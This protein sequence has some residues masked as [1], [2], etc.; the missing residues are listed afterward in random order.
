VVVLA[1]MM[2]ATTMN[3]S[4]SAAGW[5]NSASSVNALDSGT[6]PEEPTNAKAVMTTAQDEA[7][8]TTAKP[9]TFRANKARVNAL[10]HAAVADVEPA[11]SAKDDNAEVP[12]SADS[13]AWFTKD[14]DH[15]REETAS[16]ITAESRSFSRIVH[17]EDNEIILAAILESS[18]AASLEELKADSDNFYSMVPSAITIEGD[19]D[20]INSDDDFPGVEES[21]LIFD[22]QCKNCAEG[23]ASMSYLLVIN[24]IGDIVA[25]ETHNETM[26]V[27]ALHPSPTN[28][29]EVYLGMNYDAS[30]NGPAAVWN[31][32]ESVF[33]QYGE[34]GYT[35]NSHDV[36]WAEE[37]SL[38]HMPAYEE[39]SFRL[40]DLDDGHEKTRLNISGGVLPGAWENKD[41]SLVDVNHFQ[42]D[43]M[44]TRVYMSF[45]DL[46]A[47]IKTEEFNLDMNNIHGTSVGVE[48]I[49]GSHNGTFAIIDLDGT[50][51]EPG[52]TEYN[53]LYGGVGSL[54][55]GQHNLEH[56]GNGEF[57]MFDNAY[58]MNSEEWTNPD[59]SRMLIVQVDEEEET[60]TLIWE[61]QM[62]YRSEIFG[63]NDRLPSGNLLGCAWPDGSSI[64]DEV[65]FDAEIVEVVRETGELAWNMKVW[66][67]GERSSESQEIYGWMMYSVERVY[68][69]PLILSQ[70]CSTGNSADTLAFDTFNNFKQQSE[71]QG[72]YKVTTTSGSEVA[73]GAVTWSAHW[74]RTSIK[75]KMWSGACSGGCTLSLTNLAGDVGEKT[76]TC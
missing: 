34:Y 15:D 46:S 6:A 41:W 26:S 58:D 53:Q 56:F 66:G 19:L 72:T 23:D 30:E 22:L 68:E 71:V 49:A 13:Q 51:Y 42:F 69:E 75:V 14:F 25:V 64:S 11:S 16:A 17:L 39:F 48:W 24:L 4:R 50:R 28:S 57:F 35:G 60:V 73:S 32:G 21:Y 59:G 55:A 27:D 45:R 54:W 37:N 67:T 44:D 38:W 43:D 36:F 10:T 7:T 9:T 5:P 20:L 12:E 61:Y 52:T 63:D 8:V 33:T 29:K 31:W 3:S 70:T 40:M 62:G 65:A 47:F 74:A 1:V 18:G 2:V 76:F